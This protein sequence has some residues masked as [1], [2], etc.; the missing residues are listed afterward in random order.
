MFRHLFAQQHNPE[1]GVDHCLPAF[2]RQLLSGI[3]IGEQG[4]IGKNIPHVHFLF[5]YGPIQADH[6]R[7]RKKI[8]NIGAFEKVGLGREHFVVSGANSYVGTA[9]LAEFLPVGQH[10]LGPE[11]VSFGIGG[12]FV[13]VH[14]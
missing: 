1:I 2:Y 6:H 14:K 10:I 12:D 9:E 11:T 4:A 5:S 13:P 7:V 3:I 8:R